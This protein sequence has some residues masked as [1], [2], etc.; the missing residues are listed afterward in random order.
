MSPNFSNNPL[1]F[2]GL[3]GNIDGPTAT[4]EG[5]PDLSPGTAEEIGA[6]PVLPVEDRGII[7]DEDEYH[8]VDAPAR[9]FQA[10]AK[11][12]AVKNLVQDLVTKCQLS[13]EGARALAVAVVDPSSARRQLAEPQ[14]LRVLGGTFKVIHTRVWAHGVAPDPSNFRLVEIFGSPFLGKPL[15]LRHTPIPEATTV[16]PA[17]NE[18]RLEVMSRAHLEAVAVAG[19][20]KIQ[21]D[22]P[23]VMESVPLQ[24]VMMPTF[25]VVTEIFHRD[26]ASSSWVITTPDGSSRVTACHV[27]LGISTA[28]VVYDFP[29]KPQKARIL[30][31]SARQVAD[32]PRRIL[33]PDALAMNRVATLPMT[34]LIGFTPDPGG[35]QDFASAIRSLVGMLHVAPPTKWPAAGE[36]EA[37]ATAVIR[38]LEKHLNALEMAFVRGDLPAVEAEEAGFYRYLDQRAAFL[39]RLLTRPRLAPYRNL[40]DSVGRGIRSVLV[41]QEDFGVRRAQATLEIR[42]QVSFELALRPV[43]E[44]GALPARIATVRAALD[45]ALPSDLFREKAWEPTNLG[46]DEL[47]SEALEELSTAGAPGPKCRTMAAMGIWWLCLTGA[48]S[49]AKLQGQNSTEKDWREPS[50]LASDLARCPHGLRVFHSAISAGRTAQ[51]KGALAQLEIPAVAPDGSPE[52][53]GDGKV[54]IVTPHWIRT[55]VVDDHSKAPHDGGAEPHVDPKAAWNRRWSKFMT[56]AQTIR[57]GF[58]NEI[59]TMTL[60][61]GRPVVA[62]D[63]IPHD[64]AENAEK[65]L[66]SIIKK[67]TI[68]ADISRQK[69]E[70]LQPDPEEPEADLHRDLEDAD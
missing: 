19:Y 62:V 42:T 35:D 11:T 70:A 53:A 48:I 23:R 55:H 66:N 61:S 13:E 65:I 27:K 52:T 54:Q 38:A 10:M 26:T 9:H 5:H 29:N 18:L 24:G 31:D 32:T 40:H 56:D 59:L 64:Q 39:L 21:A 8:S 16:G 34:I 45:R 57:D 6:S 22:N 37:M 43:R 47:L 68:Y 4:K 30:V 3:D 17:G 25:G 2:E 36:R 28:D 51:D 15:E 60:D 20:D 58:F 50:Q 12:V 69:E 14:E 44:T 46:P 49:R 33:T 7:E 41:G 1:P 63:G 67:L